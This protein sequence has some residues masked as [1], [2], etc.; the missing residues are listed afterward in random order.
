MSITKSSRTAW[1]IFGVSL[2]IVFAGFVVWTSLTGVSWWMSPNKALADRVLWRFVAVA[3]FFSII[4][5]FFSAAPL[6]R[7][8]FFSLLAALAV[9]VAYYICGF[10]HLL[11]YG[12]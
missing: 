8:L 6:L 7:R 1:V 5:P 9:V 4:A 10:I 3:L 12:V 2:A 11:L